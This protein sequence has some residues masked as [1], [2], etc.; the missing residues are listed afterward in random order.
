MNFVKL[1]TILLSMIGMIFAAA[2]DRQGEVFADS[3][4]VQSQVLRIVRRNRT[5]F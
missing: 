3:V 5:Q 1:A 4:I 2:I